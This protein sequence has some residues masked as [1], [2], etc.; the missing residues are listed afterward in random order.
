MIDIIPNFILL[1]AIQV[2]T[3]IGDDVRDYPNVV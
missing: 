2:D 3:K 1:K